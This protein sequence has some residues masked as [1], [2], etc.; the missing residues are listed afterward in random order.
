MAENRNQDPNQR[1]RQRGR[2]DEDLGNR[3]EPDRDR[4]VNREQGGQGGS[5]SGGQ[6]ESGTGGFGQGT[7]QGG[8]RLRDDDMDSDR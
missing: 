1:D 5:R 6:R 3:M 4:T 2:Q 7:G 8:D